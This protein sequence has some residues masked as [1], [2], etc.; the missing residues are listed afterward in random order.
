MRKNNKTIILG[1]ILI[2]LVG[3]IYAYFSGPP[4]PAPLNK[5]SS[6]ETSIP[7]QTVQDKFSY[8][9]QTGKDALILLKEKAVVEQDKSGLVVSINNREA[10][11]SKR[12]YWAFY[13]NGKLA[14]VGPADYKTKDADV[15]EWKIEKY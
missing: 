12:E 9:G 7:S 6:K 1:I 3:S 4:G 10:M 15:I 13:V 2:A 5:D 11:V 14:P 8:K